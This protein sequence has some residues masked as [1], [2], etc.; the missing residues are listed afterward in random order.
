MCIEPLWWLASRT[1]TGETDAVGDRTTALQRDEPRNRWRT[2]ALVVAALGLL[3]CGA[4]VFY[5]MND[6]GR[7]VAAFIDL[8]PR[9]DLPLDVPEPGLYTIWASAIG[10]GYVETPP[11]SEMHDTLTIS[12]TGPVGSDD[13]V[14]IVPEQYHAGTR[15]RLDGARY[16]VATWTVEFPES[17]TYVLE[18]RN[19]GRSGVRLSLGEGI[20]MPSRITAGLYAIGGITVL[21]VVTLLAIG[22]WRDRRRIDEMLAGFDSFGDRT[23]TG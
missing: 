22:W 18:R 12:F 2:G 6:Q 23:R 17:G 9:S 4:W 10:G 16:G 15:Y 5:A 8:P 19:A 20:G 11:V 14:R 1:R 21:V 7:H 3:A 13:P